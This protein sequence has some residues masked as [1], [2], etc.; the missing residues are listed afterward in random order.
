MG[1]RGSKDLV[2]IESTN[3]AEV[4]DLFAHPDRASAGFYR[5]HRPLN[6]PKALGN[7]GRAGPGIDPDR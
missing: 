3:I 6:I 4:P 5:N 2:R 1:F 7:A